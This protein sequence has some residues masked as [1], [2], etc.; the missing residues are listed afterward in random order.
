MSG[1]RLNSQL[2]QVPLY[3]PGRSTEEV[4]AE[5]GLDEVIKLAS[6]ES[7]VGPSSQAV[8]AAQ[9]ML[10]QAHRYPGIAEAQLRHQL[11]EQLGHGLEA[12][13]IVTGNGATDVIHRIT[14][15]FVFDGGNT[16]MS[17]VTFPMY[18]IATNIF[19]G[20]PRRV[21]AA[22]DFQQDLAAMA[23]Q[24]DEDTRLVYLCSPNNPTGQ[25]IPQAEVKAFMA[26]V[27]EH[28]VVLFDESYHDFVTDPDYPET[29]AYVQQERPVLVLRSFSKSAGLA[30][31]RV[32]Y[33]IGPKTLTNY[34]R[35]T[36]LP[37]HTSAIAL[38]AASASLD[39]LEFRRRI[40]EAVV[41]GREFL[42][43]ALCQLGLDCLP[44]QTNFVL[45]VDPPTGA[46]A[47][48][49][50]LLRQGIIVR[51]MGGFGMPNAVR[52]SV[53]SLAD[54]VKCITAMKRVLSEAGH[55][56]PIVETESVR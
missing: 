28:V 17:Q 33:A 55:A 53:G 21:P 12:D 45:I 48:T 35:R 6:N 25:I 43:T 23:S 13:Q 8:M 36:Q 56:Q 15:A 16:V 3:V 44:S 32:G 9:A 26:Q 14:Q 38:T 52:I 54:N 34:V 29:L 37:F 5:L 10:E 11:A 39:D 49:E 31:M 51:A 18:A 1:P 19:G 24:I 41:S 40:K 22:A 27:P 42:H 4:R 2:L 50:S 47:L 30:N 20:T 7:P 46:A